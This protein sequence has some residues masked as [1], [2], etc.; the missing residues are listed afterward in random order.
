[1]KDASS[2]AVPP[3]RMSAIFFALLF[4]S[5]TIRR[6]RRS[7]VAGGFRRPLG[8]GARV[9]GVSAIKSRPLTPVHGYARLVKSLVTGGA[10]FI[11]S[12]LTDALVERGDEVLV[13]DDLSTG[14]REN[15]E[16]AL[17]AR[18]HPRESRHHRP[19]ALLT[20]VE[21]FE[22]EAVFHL[23]AQIDVRKS[24]ADPDLDVRLNVLGT[25]NVLEAARLATGAERFVFT[26]TGGAIYGEGDERAGELPFAEDARLRAVRVYGQSK[27]AAEGYLGL[28]RR[29][30]GLNATVGPARQ[31][32]RA[33][34]GPRARGRRGR[35]L[36]RARPRRRA[37]DR[38]RRT[39]ARPGTT[40]MWPTSS[41]GS[42]PRTA[43]ISP[44]PFNIG[45][46]TE[47]TVLELAEVIGRLAL[48]DD[49]EPEF[50]PHREGEVERTALAIDLAKSELGWQPQ[51]DLE[52]GLAET[53]AAEG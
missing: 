10:G 8:T 43:P 21:G 12:H 24:M 53:L 48:R 51:R 20:A 28:Y 27:L 41:P 22:P 4:F 42:S 40:Y 19:A 36:L 1:M 6:I 38:L 26:S 29:A 49:F 31:R 11:G 9:A 39:A 50:A 14:K 37:P 46:G 18:R 34:A 30:H 44:G 2:F 17:A 3:L 32:L 5:V 47:T 15:L 7:T 25:V 45:T 23:A 52:K 16:R 33:A 13:L 35:D